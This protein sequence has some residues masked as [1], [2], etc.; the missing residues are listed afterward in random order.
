MHVPTFSRLD[1]ASTTWGKIFLSS[2]VLT[3]RVVAQ[4]TLLLHFPRSIAS[5]MPK[6]RPTN[7]IRGVWVDE[8]AKT[9]RHGVIV[10]AN[11][12]SG[13]KHQWIVRFENEDGTTS[14]EPRTSSG[15]LVVV[16]IYCCA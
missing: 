15:I 7:L 3:N 13:K 12:D 14:E 8:R 6:E 16:R 11:R 5:K 1:V 9:K 2:V 4:S 10:A